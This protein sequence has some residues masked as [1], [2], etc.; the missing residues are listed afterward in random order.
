MEGSRD[1]WILEEDWAKNVTNSKNTGNFGIGRCSVILLFFIVLFNNPGYIVSVCTCFVCS[2][3]CL[4]WQPRHPAI[5]PVNWPCHLQLH[6]GAS[7]IAAPH[8]TAI[9]IGISELNS[10]ILTY[11]RPIANSTPTRLPINASCSLASGQRRTQWISSRCFSTASRRPLHS[12]RLRAVMKK[13]F[14]PTYPACRQYT[15]RL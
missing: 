13:I 3:F 5:T 7:S 12:L 14:C 6:V 4:A 1:N 15:S 10:R 2:Q 9:F 11:N 8:P